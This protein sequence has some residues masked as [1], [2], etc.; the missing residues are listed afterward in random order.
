M[1]KGDLAILE[2]HAA[3]YG[4]TIGRWSPGD[5]LMRYRFYIAPAGTKEPIGRCLGFAAAREWLHAYMRGFE[6]G[7]TT[8]PTNERTI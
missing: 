7:L 1:E 2:S 4:L 6:A 3:D 8:T 5:G